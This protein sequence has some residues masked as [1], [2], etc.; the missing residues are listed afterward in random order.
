MLVCVLWG[1]L[2]VRACVRRSRR[3]RAGRSGLHPL[4]AW[5][6]PHLSPALTFCRLSSNP[7]PPPQALRRSE[8]VRSLVVGG[9]GF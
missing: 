2:C 5:G 3:L 6:E 8:S 7:N 9:L 4:P 1:R